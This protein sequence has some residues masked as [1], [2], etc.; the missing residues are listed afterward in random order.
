MKALGSIL[1]T[2]RKNKT[3]PKTENKAKMWTCSAL[4]Q[5]VREG[6]PSPVRCGKKRSQNTDG[7]PQSSVFV[8]TESKYVKKGL[9]LTCV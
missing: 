5:T 7:H 1:S 9:N 3:F 6:P 2:K 8:H 4:S